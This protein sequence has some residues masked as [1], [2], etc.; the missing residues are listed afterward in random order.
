[1]GGSVVSGR[2]MAM[3]ILLMLLLMLSLLLP[4]MSCTM[5]LMEY[6][7]TLHAHHAS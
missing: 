6:F 4:L 7:P 3:E 5:D 1:M 2:A